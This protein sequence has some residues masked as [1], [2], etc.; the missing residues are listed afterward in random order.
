MSTWLVPLRVPVVP[1]GQVMWAPAGAMNLP[2]RHTKPGQG[3]EHRGTNR[4]IAGGAAAVHAAGTAAAAAAVDAT[5]TTGGIGQAGGRVKGK[6]NR[7]PR[8]GATGV[9][10]NQATADPRVGGVIPARIA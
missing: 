4:A 7:R 9:A 5:T 8:H 10:N 1:A 3:T 6:R 2:L